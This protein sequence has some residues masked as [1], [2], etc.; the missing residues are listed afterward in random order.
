MSFM[1]AGQARKKK[2]FVRKRP[3]WD[4]TQSDLDA[5]RATPDEVRARRESH[6]SKNHIA[7]KLEKI[8]KEKQ[9]QR[10]GLTNVEARQ[11]AIMKEVLHDQQQLDTVLSKTDH[12]LAMVKDLF[13]DDAKKFT[14][15]PN[16]TLPPGSQQSGNTSLPRAPQIRTRI[17]KL[18]ESIVSQSALNDF[19]GSSADESEEDKEGQQPEP[20]NFQSRLD[21]QSYQQYLQEEEN[22]NSN[23]IPTGGSVGVS[24]ADIQRLQQLQ[25]ILLAQD[26]HQGN[27]VRD[28]NHTLSTISGNVAGSMLLGG[29]Q[30][31]GPA[32]STQLPGEQ[33][34][35]FPGQHTPPTS[36]RSGSGSRR[37]PTKSALNDTG[38]VNKSRRRV[39]PHA[40]PSANTSSAMN[41]GDMRQVLRTLHAEIA[42]FE[43][44]TGRRSASDVQNTES[45][46]GYTVALVTAVAKLTHY[47]KETE[48]RLQAEMMVREQLAQDV[49]QLTVTI[50]SVTQEMIVTQEEYGRL[51][52][53][54]HNYRQQ[55]QGEM[56]LLQAQVLELKHQQSTQG[57]RHSTPGKAAS[58]G[59]D[60]GD[61][62]YSELP[63]RMTQPSAAAVLLTPVVRKTRVTDEEKLEAQKPK[64]QTSLVDIPSLLADADP[65]QHQSRQHSVAA[66]KAQTSMAASVSS[67]SSGRPD[68][69]RLTQTLPVMATVNVPRPI[70]LIQSNLG[71]PLSG[72]QAAGPLSQSQS[73]PSRTNSLVS[74]GA[75]GY[76]NTITTTTSTAATV[77]GTRAMESQIAELNRQHAEAQLRLQSLLEQ[78]KRQHDQLQQLQDDGA[79]V[80]DRAG[81]RVV[82]QG[83]MPGTVSPPISPISLRSE[84]FE[85]RDPAQ[86][87]VSMSR[88][89]KVAMPTVD[90]EVSAGSFNSS[91]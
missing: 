64:R 70:P 82:Q 61:E 50:D 13:G 22:S 35:S 52:S 49:Q 85:Q 77:E 45:F 28:N 71:V 40:S 18:S 56:A 42:D 68:P 41:M 31:Q 48:L 38:K 79:V 27:S 30:A 24:Q 39:Q 89:I 53:E 87:L 57:S 2:A 73:H 83:T 55:V 62:N 6:K 32:H 69:P 74:G 4:D 19:S 47:M 75:A 76:N 86:R 91:V 1:R 58:A 88:E 84:H 9:K 36:D 59:G 20:M 10:T 8:R 65:P 60:D 12:M 3:Q 29:Q 54:F 81:S 90:L 63:E 43:R 78:Q 16:V 34:A 11:V 7:V 26:R 21:L 15:H 17:E 23:A 51:G 14:G 5:Y 66:S 44:R 72:S 33:F 37:T 25:Q 67:T 46:T 80:G